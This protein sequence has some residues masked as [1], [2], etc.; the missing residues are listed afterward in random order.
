MG[1]QTARAPESGDLDALA[2]SLGL[3]H[4]ELRQNLPSLTVRAYAAGAPIVREG[5][6]GADLFILIKGS[7]SVRVARWLVFSK[8]VAR[9][10]SGDLFG[11]I[12][13]VAASQRTA[14]VVAEE[15]VEVL[16]ILAP[17][18]KGL[19]ER[20]PGLRKAIEEMARQHL[21]GLSSS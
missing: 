12:G 6:V 10:K 21:Y 19:L 8:E 18:M 16:R 11:E 17:E 4:V 2:K 20:K 9:L 15:P 5:Q 1:S 14:S 7:A 13:F 3:G